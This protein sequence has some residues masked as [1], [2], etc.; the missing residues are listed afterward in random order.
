MPDQPIYNRDEAERVRDIGIAA[1]EKGDLKRASWAF[2]KSKQLYAL[3]GIDEWILKASSSSSSS[4]QQSTPAPP[5][6]PQPAAQARVEVE[7]T[8]EQHQVVKK[9]IGAVDYYE[10]L[11]V[12]VTA[13]EEE[14]KK[15]Y[16]KVCSLS[17]YLSRNSFHME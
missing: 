5:P 15:Q 10:K 2:N 6:P 17:P 4:T 14:I 3:D 7:Y 13:T 8:E 16:R 9:I 1:F 12:S 11:S